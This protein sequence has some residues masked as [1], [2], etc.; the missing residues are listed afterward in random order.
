MTAFLLADVA[1]TLRDHGARFA[2]VFGSR[3]RGD[4]RRDSDLDVAAW[5]GDP[6]P[7]AFEVPV[8]A[9]VDLVVL[10][11]APLELSGRIAMDGVVVLDDDPPARVRWL[12]R[13]RK[14][15]ADERYRIEQAHADFASAV[16]SGR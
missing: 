1:A 2:F 13:T 9:G 4:E 14:I 15:Y 11:T 7:S 3:A 8:P 12:A 16:R 10:N 5:F 6:V